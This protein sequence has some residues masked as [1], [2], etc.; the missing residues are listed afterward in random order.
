[1]SSA[2]HLEDN[3]APIEVV[4]L[5]N[6]DGHFKIAMA[7]VVLGDKSFDLLTAEHTEH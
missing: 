4:R 5:G 1:M 7:W 6:T 2:F 3:E